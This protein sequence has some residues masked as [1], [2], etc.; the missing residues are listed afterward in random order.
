MEMQMNNSYDAVIVGGGIAGGALATLL[1]RAGKEVLVLEKSTEYRDRV[2]GEWFAPWGVLELRRLGLYDT[3]L[4]AG[5]HHL[6]YHVTLGDDQDDPEAA[7]ARPLDMSQLL[8]EIPGPLTIR[9]TVACQALIA[10]AATAG[11]TVLRGVDH[12]RV[13]PG[14]A[15]A[16]EFLHGGS[17][18]HVRCRLIVGADGRTSVV[19][20]QAGIKEHHGIRHN[21]FSGM[22]VEGAHGWPDDLQVKGTEREVNF[23]AFPQG[24]GRVRL[25]LGYGFDRKTLLAGSDAPDRFLEEFRLATVPGS[26]ALANATP[27]SHC[28]SYPNEDTW[29]DQP[30]SEGLVLIGDAAGHNDPIIGQGL[31][32]TMRDVRLVTEALLSSEAWTSSI[33]AGYAEE[34]RERLRRLRFAAE[35]QATL[36]G[37]F[38]PEAS[39]RRRR[40]RQ[41]Q[42]ADPSLSLPFLSVMVG[43]EMIP[44]FAFEDVV[45]EK[46]LAE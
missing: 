10:E 38:G 12:V 42:A 40:S 6:R 2:R 11:A 4:A 39:A 31:S 34:R 22:L 36:D 19:R 45:R 7:L 20:G 16:V 30:Y 18:H 23:L 17:S 44:P 33:F 14:N 3:L 15:P 43:P 41:R 35:L 27:V 24:G 5:G 13:L 8:P 28:Y 37:E 1:A 9:H 29:C 26:D 25:Y 21:L 46:L 32:I